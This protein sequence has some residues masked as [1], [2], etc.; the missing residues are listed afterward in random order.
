MK[1]ILFA[2]LASLLTACSGRSG[3]NIGGPDTITLAPCPTFNADT[4]MKYIQEQCNFGP[5]VTVSSVSCGAVP[6]P[7]CCC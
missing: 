7:W 4:C 5:R 6:P 2:V 1:Y 3:R